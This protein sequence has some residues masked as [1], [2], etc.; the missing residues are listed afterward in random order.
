MNGFTLSRS[1]SRR[2]TL[3][4][5]LSALHGWM[6]KPPEFTDQPNA[7]NLVL[8]YVRIT[9]KQAHKSPEANS[10]ATALNAQI[11]IVSPN[12]HTKKKWAKRS[13]PCCRNSSQKGRRQ[14]KGSS[15]HAPHERST[16]PRWIQKSILDWPLKPSH[17]GVFF[18]VTSCPNKSHFRRYRHCCWGSFLPGP[19]QCEPIYFSSHIPRLFFPLSF[20]LIE[21]V[22]LS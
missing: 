12:T 10:L 2:L 1:V 13:L 8:A 22:R 19:V 20:W 18:P 21:S 9:C 7:I 4:L 3:P 11:C 14:A 17:A 6:T 15:L 16:F 5:S